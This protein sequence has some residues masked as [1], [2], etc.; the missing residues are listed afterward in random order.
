MMMKVQYYLT[1]CVE[2]KIIG[3]EKLRTMLLVLTDRTM[4]PPYVKI[5]SQ[6]RLPSWNY[7]AKKMDR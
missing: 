7:I 2:V 1:W 6:Q 4:L 5:Y 3:K